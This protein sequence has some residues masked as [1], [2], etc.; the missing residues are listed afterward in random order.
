MKKKRILN[1]N[2]KSRKTDLNMKTQDSKTGEKPEKRVKVTR[3][4]KRKELK[5][6]EEEEDEHLRKKEEMG[7][8]QKR[9]RKWLQALWVGVMMND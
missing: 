6:L 3:L 4:H 8:G 5:T 2:E 7:L 9:V 1:Q